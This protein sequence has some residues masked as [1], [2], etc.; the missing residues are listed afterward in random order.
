[1]DLDVCVVVQSS[2]ALV[3]QVE[4]VSK[5]TTVMHGVLSFGIFETERDFDC[6]LKHVWIDLSLSFLM[7]EKSLVCKQD[8]VPLLMA[9]RMSGSQLISPEC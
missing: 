8:P 7:A 4:I 9:E 2:F 6:N 3:I 1:M 5:K